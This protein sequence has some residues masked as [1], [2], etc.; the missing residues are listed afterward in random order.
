MGLL[1]LHHTILASHLLASPDPLPQSQAPIPSRQGSLQ[2]GH[3]EQDSDWGWDTIPNKND[4]SFWGE[5]LGQFPSLFY[6]SF[7]YHLIIF[8][9]KQNASIAFFIPKHKIN[10][11]IFKNPP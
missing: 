1:T 7:L 4:E 3:S 8:F 9:S 11:A 5:D 2:D 10:D 6:F